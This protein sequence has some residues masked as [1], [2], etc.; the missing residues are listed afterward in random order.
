MIT[1][2]EPSAGQENTITIDYQLLLS[3]QTHPSN[4]KCNSQSTS[5]FNSHNLLTSFAEASSHSTYDTQSFGD[6]QPLRKYA[7]ISGFIP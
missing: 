7:K 1:P 2:H 5:S 3:A 4:S 6:T